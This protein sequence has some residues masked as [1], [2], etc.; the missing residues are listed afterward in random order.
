MSRARWYCA[1]LR[2]GP[3][4]RHGLH[5]RECR[6][7][8][9]CASRSVQR[10]RRAVVSSTSCSTKIS[11]NP[12]CEITLNVFEFRAISSEIGAAQSETAQGSRSCM[13]AGKGTTRET[14][15]AGASAYT[16]ADMERARDRMEV[17]KRRL[18]TRLRVETNPRRHRQVKANTVNDGGERHGP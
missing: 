3:A 12:V 6:Q 1:A 18:R 7:Q 14:Y 5:R 4:H 11:A 13:E 17:A 9:P 8:S 16:V 2:H 15:P 10:R